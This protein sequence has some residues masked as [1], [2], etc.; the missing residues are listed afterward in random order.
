MSYLVVIT[1]YSS[2]LLFVVNFGCVFLFRNL[3]F[4]HILLE[5]YCFSIFP[6][7]NLPEC[8]RSLGIYTP[9]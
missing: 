3:P 5:M 4:C 8:P 6:R 9:T 7:Y 2:Y 1:T